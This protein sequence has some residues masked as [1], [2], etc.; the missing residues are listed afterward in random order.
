MDATE[1]DSQKPEEI[2]FI[3]SEAEMQ[4]LYE[5]FFASDEDNNFKDFDQLVF[6]D[7]FNKDLPEIDT[8]QVFPDEL[9][10]TSQW[11]F[12][13]LDIINEFLDPEVPEVTNENVLLPVTTSNESTNLNITKTNSNACENNNKEANDFVK[14]C[15]VPLLNMNYTTRSCQL[16][17]IN[18]KRDKKIR[19]AKF[20]PRKS[21]I[22][23][24]IT[25]TEAFSKIPDYYKAV[26]PQLHASKDVDV[27]GTHK[28]NMYDKLPS[29]L[30]EFISC[31]ATP[32]SVAKQKDSC[33]ILEKL[34]NQNEVIPDKRETEEENKLVVER[35]VVHVGNIK[36][37]ITREQLY[38]RFKVFGPI[39]DIRLHYRDYGDCYAFITFKFT[40]DA[41]D[42]VENKLMEVVPINSWFPTG[43]VL[44]YWAP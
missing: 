3:L 6:G 22:L 2:D 31:K 18:I 37:G 1:T 15:Y 35:R 12:K 36:R 5:D 42:A 21:G 26:A 17:S 25:G 16:A 27:E 20:D 40:T 8:P 33:K 32:D 7:D 28:E 34:K 29:Y 41:F 38:T 9:S 44:E 19:Q 10:T 39:E 24:P 43:P 23:K 14:M 11:D 13:R 30:T 4:L